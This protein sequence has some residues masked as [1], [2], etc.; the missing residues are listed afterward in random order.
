M[1][2]GYDKMGAL[3]GG[4]KNIDWESQRL[5]KFE[6]N[7]YVEDKRITA[8]SDSEIAEFRRVKEIKVCRFSWSSL[9]LLS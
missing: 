7:F 8:K 6:K 1:G 4:L 5:E 2:G 3:G 9:S